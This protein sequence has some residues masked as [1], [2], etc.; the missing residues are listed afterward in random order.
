[1]TLRA[2]LPLEC[3]SDARAV[4]VSSAMDMHTS[5]LAAGLLTATTFRGAT[6]HVFVLQEFLARRRAARARFGAGLANERCEGTAAGRNLGSRGA[7]VGTVL[8]RHQR[9]DVF[10]VTGMHL[11]GAMG[12]TRITPA[13]AVRT[14]FGTRLQSRIMLAVVRRVATFFGQHF[15]TEC[16]H[17][18]SRQ[19]SQ[20]ELSSSKHDCSPGLI[21]HQVQKKRGLPGGKPLT[22]HLFAQPQ[23]THSHTSHVQN[24]PLQSGHLQTSQPHFPAFVVLVSLFEAQQ[25]FEAATN[26]IADKRLDTGVRALCL[27]RQ[28]Q[29]PHVHRSHEQDSPLQSGQRQS[30]QAH[31][32]SF[33]AAEDV[34][35]PANA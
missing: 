4:A 29:L 1:M 19:T 6:R 21:A 17:G 5:H 8:T 11:M 34:D 33:E 2:S 27:F 24:S 20:S 30:T 22:S 13:L 26:G 9:G 16:S 7:E 32:G 3:G 35:E 12:R 15:P 18:Q 28:P 31:P 10:L 23:L 25:L 14:R